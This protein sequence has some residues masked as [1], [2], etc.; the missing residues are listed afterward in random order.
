MALGC[1][2]IMF[3]RL[4]MMKKSVLFYGVFDEILKEIALGCCKHPGEKFYLQPKTSEA[5]KIIEDVSNLPLNLYLTTSENI[6]TVC[7]Q[8]E[9][10]KWENKQYVPPDYLVNLSNKMA[11]LQPS[12]TNRAFLSFNGEVSI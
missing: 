10:T 5:I 3:G 7:Y 12:E 11:T 2:C 4:K 6:T 8:C 1:I 9:I